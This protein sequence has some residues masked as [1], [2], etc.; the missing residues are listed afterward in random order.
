MRAATLILGFLAGLVLIGSFQDPP[1]PPM[2]VV[3]E[4]IKIG[5]IGLLTDVPPVDLDRPLD[6][7]STVNRLASR[8]RLMTGDSE[9]LL[10][11]LQEN[12]KGMKGKGMNE[13]DLFKGMNGNEQSFLKS[14]LDKLKSDPSAFDSLKGMGGNGQSLDGLKGMIDGLKMDGMKMPELKGGLP[15]L[16]GKAM[17]GITLPENAPQWMRDALAGWEKNVGPIKNN[18]E[19]QKML[20]GFLSKENGFDPSKWKEWMNGKGFDTSKLD[21]LFGKNGPKLDLSKVPDPKLNLNLGNSKLPSWNFGSPSISP[22]SAPS[23]G[24]WSFGGI[25]GSGLAS[26]TPILIILAIAVVGVLVWMYWPQIKES[27]ARRSGEP[28]IALP[29]GFDPRLVTDR[30]TLIRAFELLS[31]VLCGPTAKTWNHVTIGGALK[32]F[33][34]TNPA[35]GEQLAVLYALARYTPENEPLTPEAIAQ[36][37]SA[38]CTLA[39]VPA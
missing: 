31:V 22:P 16:S 20:D 19:L 36:A 38:L 13:K 33:L 23:M 4:G 15:D 39:G 7:D 2:P 26:L 21:G 8:L 24:G 5:R 27:L 30:P 6:G 3:P 32:E 37:R 12:A 18:P 1:P 28:A 25:G 35:G 17:G 10:K 11:K 34:T 9:S 29:E 14:L